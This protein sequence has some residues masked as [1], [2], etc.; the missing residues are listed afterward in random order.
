MLC[1]QCN[2][3][4]KVLKKPSIHFHSFLPQDT[5]LDYQKC[6]L[7]TPHVKCLLWFVDQP[8]SKKV[9][10]SKLMVVDENGWLNYAIKYII[11][12]DV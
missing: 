5:Q 8:T 11:S 12:K 1:N 4:E 7:V 3:A 6:F 2:N 9:W 10:I